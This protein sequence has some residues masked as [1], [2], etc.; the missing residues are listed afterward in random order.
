VQSFLNS[1]GQPPAARARWISVPGA[2]INVT[3]DRDGYPYVVNSSKS[4]YHVN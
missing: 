3:V 4:A 1:G 2:A